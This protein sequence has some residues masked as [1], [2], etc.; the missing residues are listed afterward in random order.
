MA[1]FDLYNPTEQ[2]LCL[3]ETVRKFGQDRLEPQA[4]TFDDQE[5]FNDPLFRAFGAELGLFGVTVPED[6]GGAGMDPVALVIIHEELSKYDPGLMLSY[7]AHEVL[8]VHNLHVNGNEEQR[9]RYLPRTLSGDWIGGLAMTE[10]GVGTDVLGMS[11]RAENKGGYYVLNGVKQFITN[12]PVGDVFLVYAKTGPTPK[13]I[14]LFLVEKTFRGFSVG[15]KEEKMGM[16]SSPTSQLVFEDMEVPAENLIGKESG[17]LV[18]MMRNLEI[19]RVTLG[20]QS[21][22]I[23]LRCV[24]IMSRYA[25]AERTAFGEPL[26]AF[27]QIQ[28]FLAESYAKTEAARSLLYHVAQKLHSSERQSLGAASAKLIATIS[29]EEIARN[30]IQVLGGYGYCREYAVERLYRDAVLLSIGGGTNEA[31]QKNIVADL[32]R[33][34]RK[35]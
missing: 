24:E 22:G 30:A 3:R 9:Q 1:K 13:D 10:P 31:M 17:G 20:A 4:K 12:G 32:V 33:I 29:A 16:K 28:R 6:D 25:I 26:S 35:R 18:P 2:H 11:C 5:K 27:G 23:A 19:E 7:L 21:L 14:S 34:Y 15:K 8:F